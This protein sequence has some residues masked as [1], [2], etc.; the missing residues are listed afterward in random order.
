MKVMTQS[1]FIKSYGHNSKMTEKRMN[2]LGLFAIPC[3]CEDE[4][5]NGWAMISKENVKA[6][7]DLYLRR[8]NE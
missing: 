7:V 8:N 3:E 2:E 5:C 1:E 6:H 4:N